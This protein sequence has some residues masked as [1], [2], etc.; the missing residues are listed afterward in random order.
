VKDLVTIFPVLR[1]WLAEFLRKNNQMTASDIGHNQ[2]VEQV[3][4]KYAKK[5]T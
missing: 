1:D 3:F 4:Y 2:L 5:T